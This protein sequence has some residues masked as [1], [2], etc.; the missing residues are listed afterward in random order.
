MNGVGLGRTHYID[1]LGVCTIR[2]APTTQIDDYVFMRSFFKI[3]N[4]YICSLNPCK[5]EEKFWNWKSDFL[6]QDLES[7]CFGKITSPT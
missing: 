2:K 3:R 4:V 7:E 5:N 6:C 1:E